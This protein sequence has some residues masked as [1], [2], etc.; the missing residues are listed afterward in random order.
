MNVYSVGGEEEVGNSLE[1]PTKR[2]AVE[3]AALE[4]FV[5][6]GFHGTTV[7]DIAR[8][9]DV[10]TGTLYL[11]HCSKEKLLNHLYQRWQT[12][13]LGRLTVAARDARTPRE[14]F[15]AFWHSFVRFT[16]E[17]PVAFQFIMMYESS[18]YLS[19][20]TRRMAIESK[21]PVEALF[22]DGMARQVFKALP[23]PVLMAVAKGV[24]H[25]LRR[26]EASGEVVLT[27]ALWKAAEGM[28]WE[29]IRR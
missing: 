8:R 13:C 12:A 25:E 6:R 5:E 15:A 2:A 29:A 1:R 10:G 3:K 27:P 23:I 19:D 18:P 11:Y 22:E 17:Y 21:R 16:D 9:A 14:T 26:L 20:E 24:F 7:P 4:L 28:V